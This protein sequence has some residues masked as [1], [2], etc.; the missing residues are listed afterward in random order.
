MPQKYVTVSDVATLVHHRG[1]T[2]LPGHPPDTSKGRVVLCLH[3]AGGNGNV[4]SAL[5]DALATNQSPV[6]FD[7]PGHG[8][9]GSLDSLD[10][11]AAMAAHARSFA[12]TLGL[13][14]PVLLGEGLG[15]AVAI[16]AAIADPSWPR[17]LVLVGGAALR[18]AGLGNL[19]A[20]IELLARITS[21]KARREFD[22]SGY[23]PD[24]GKEVYGF[25][26]AEWVRTD[27]RATLGAR[28]AQAAWDGTG[29]LGAV[30]CPVLVVV[31]EH[32]EDHYRAAADSLAA[33]LANARTATLAGA[34]RRGT[35]E[36]PAALAALVDGFLQEVSA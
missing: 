5:S 13:D 1:P 21:G 33:A 15:V 3:D 18:Y 4:F 23:A 34:G 6:A 2:T 7:L 36:A 31:G 9:S 29:R 16:E 25:A 14:R 20:E 19:D 27:P 22:R 30:A 10:S 26:F 28:R 35:I 17:A 32:E 12:T 8:R 11:V 24:T